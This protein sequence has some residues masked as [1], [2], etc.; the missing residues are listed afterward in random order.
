[1]RINLKYEK[2]DIKR[3]IKK[4]CSIYVFYINI[5]SLMF[6]SNIVFKNVTIKQNDILLVDI[7][8]RKGKVFSKYYVNNF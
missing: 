6:F 4:Q 7:F 1:M 3:C 5:K 8:S 2:S